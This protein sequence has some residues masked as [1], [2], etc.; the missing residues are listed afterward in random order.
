MELSNEEYEKV[1]NLTRCD[2]KDTPGDVSLKTILENPLFNR[3]QV[4]SNQSIRV[5]D[6]ARLKYLYVSE[7]IYEMTG[8]TREEVEAG[9]LWFTYKRIHPV[10]LLKLGRV[11]LK[12]RKALNELTNEEKLSSRFTFD[13]RFK[14]KDSKYRCILQNV[15]VLS[16]SPTGKPHILLFTSSDI[17]FYKRGEAMNYS[18]D[19]HKKGKG[20]VNVLEGSL[21]S[22]T[23]PLSD[24]E[25]E[26]LKLTSEGLSEREISDILFLSKETVKTHRRN[27]LQKTEAKN[28]VDLVRMGI[29]NGWI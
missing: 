15:H 18:L 17:S 8:Y 19:T 9:G 20:F 5:L 6:N 27:M 26:I 29:A 10:D 7:S 12:V 4:F 16:L 3:L 24:R 23:Q 28:S 2:P 13:I 21:R 25:V 1:M 22:E 14:C 11:L